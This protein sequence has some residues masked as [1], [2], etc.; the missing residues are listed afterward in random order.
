MNIQNQTPFPAVSWESADANKQW[1]IT[2]LV[3]VKYVFKRAGKTG[4]WILRLTP[5]QGQ[6]F[7]GDIFY[8]DDINQP[9][10]YESDFVT[11]KQNTDVIVN[12]KTHS[13]SGKPETEW[14]CGLD[15]I[16]VKGQMLNRSCVKVSGEHHWQ[17]KALSGWTTSKIQPVTEVSLAYDHAYGGTLF[18]PD[19]NAEPALLAYDEYN[20][21]GTGI[22][23]KDMA[24][25]PHPAH[26][27]NWVD[28]A[29]QEKSYPAGFGFTP[30]SCQPRLRYAG[31]YDQDWLDHQHPYPPRDFDYR[32]HQAA[33]P[34]LIMQGYITAHTSIHLKHLLGQY[35]QAYFRI[36][37]LHCF[38]EQ[39][40]TADEVQRHPMNIDTVL[41][42][43]ADEDESH[44]AVYLSYR[45]FTPL[46]TPLKAITFQYLPTELLAEQKKEPAQRTS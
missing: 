43:I 7:A 32:H 4:E 17:K 19:Q 24:T 39:V 6:L 38:T 12:A 21:V 14:A 13:P 5:D 40:T 3:R 46:K 11:Y 10:R 30:R 36:P 18:N 29:L 41:I 22:K 34:E 35:P 45:Y 8:D 20:A 31:T 16:S 44:W 23:H 28:E 1:H 9:V 33:N 2:S 42:E 15:I 26:Q 27:V 37:E 25:N